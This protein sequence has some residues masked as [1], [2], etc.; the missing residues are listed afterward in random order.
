FWAVA[1]TEL[2]LGLGIA[3]FFMPI[4]T[5]LLSDLDG[6]E[7]AEGSGSATF[8]RTVGA[9]FAVSIVTFLWTRGGAVSHANLAEHINPFNDE[10]RRGVA[11]MGGLLQHYLAEINGVI[12]Q[13]A[14]QISF[15][16]VFDG[17][18]IGFFGL[19]AVVWLAK[20]P[21]IARRGAGSGGH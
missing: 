14:M 8:L 19:I 17:L 16:H 21:F 10:V 9:S 13:Q 6:P 3:L 4:L 2:M 11:A 12:T 7:I 1:L 18:G 15:N 5:I 20:P